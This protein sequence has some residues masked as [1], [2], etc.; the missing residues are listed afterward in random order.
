M[1]E[2]KIKFEIVQQI[3]VLYEGSK[4][5]KELNVVKWGDNDPKFDIRTWDKEHTQPGKGVTLSPE[6]IQKLKELLDLF[7]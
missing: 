2:I 6:E 5:R 4:Y 7:E 3:G 1:S